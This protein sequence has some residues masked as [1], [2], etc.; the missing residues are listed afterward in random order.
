VPGIERMSGLLFEHP[1]SREHDASRHLPGHPERP[2]RIEAVDAALAAVNWLDWERRVAPAATR[3]E[4]EAVH[5]PALIDR[6]ERLSE[7]GGGGA[8]CAR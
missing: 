2:E 1:S 5:A 3:S 4:L 7:G 8:R 6:V